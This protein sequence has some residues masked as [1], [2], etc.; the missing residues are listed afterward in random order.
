M[1][2]IQY[3]NRL[4]EQE[5]IE[6]LQQH[7]GR[8]EQIHHTLDL[9]DIENAKGMAVSGRFARFT[10]EQNAVIRTELVVSFGRRCPYSNK[11]RAG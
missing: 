3:V 8:I 9:E 4:R 7:G 1:N 5:Y 11:L 6:I 2:S 10:P